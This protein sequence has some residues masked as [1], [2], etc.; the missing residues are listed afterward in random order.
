METFGETERDYAFTIVQS[1]K[2]KA[3]AALANSDITH[4][5]LEYISKNADIMSR[6]YAF[7]QSEVDDTNN[8]NS[9]TGEYG[10]NLVFNDLRQKYKQPDNYEVIWSSKK[11]EAR[12]DFEVRH[13]G[14]T[15]LFV[16]AKTTMRGI[17][18][19]DS[20]PF[21]MRN[22]QWEFLPSVEVDV[23]YLIARVFKKENIIMYL[24]INTFNLR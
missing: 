19:S 10:E 16:D 8:A 12:F 24:Q 5:E 20:I 6:L 15:V 18:N 2:I 9:E 17:S 1:G 14:K 3:L 21:F 22:S 4:E 11:G 13:R 23:K 7:L